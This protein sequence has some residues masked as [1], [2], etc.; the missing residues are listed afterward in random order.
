MPIYNGI[1]NQKGT[2]AF[3][4][5]IFA[6]RPAFG[7]AGRVFIS[8]DTGAIYEDTG[9]S[10][11][12]IADAGAGTTGT[13]QQ[14]TTNGNTTTQGVVITTGNLA[15]GTATASAPLDIHEG[16]LGQLIQLN[17]TSTN[18]TNIGFLNGNVGK[19]RIGNVY[20]AGAN[21]FNIFNIGTSSNAL[22]F[23]STTNAAT[24]IAQIDGTTA[25]FSTSIGI[26]QSAGAYKL[27]VNGQGRFDNNVITNGI[28][29]LTLGGTSVNDAGLHS[30]LLIEMFG[31]N[32]GGTNAA[33]R[34]DNQ[35]T[36]TK[37]MGLW[38]INGGIN[39]N[40][41]AY[42]PPTNGLIVG[43]AVLINSTTDDT[44]NKLQ[45]TGSA[46]I[47]SNATIGGLITQGG[48]IYKTSGQFS[49]GGGATGT[50]YTFASSNTNQV[51][52]ISVRQA[53]GGQNT[54]VGACFL[55][56]ASSVAYNFAQDN[57]NPVLYLTLSTSGLGLQLTVGAGYGTTTW[58]YTITIIK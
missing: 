52:L 9:S 14:V 49:L 20:N 11:T 39:I 42:T 43:G 17:A 18:N 16:T 58:D 6:N 48:G 10:W 44:I 32:T 8:T 35:S 2:P 34:I 1:I 7:Y 3:F 38:V 21:S 57:T 29:S 24:F 54:V 13:L 56:G 50:F 46:S 51:Y 27:N 33:I 37:K 22:S 19:W 47:S 15:I 23:N 31:T 45:V 36:A 4:S 25:Y 26:N 28:T 41:L 55:Y 30:C 53:G 12:L 40:T 5:D